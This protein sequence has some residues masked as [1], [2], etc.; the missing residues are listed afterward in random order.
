[1]AEMFLVTSFDLFV[2][3]FKKSVSDSSMGDYAVLNG[4]DMSNLN[5][6]ENQN[7]VLA[8]RVREIVKRYIPVATVEF[9]HWT[10]TPQC[11][12]VRFILGADMDTLKGIVQRLNLKPGDYEITNYEGALAYIDPVT[13]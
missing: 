4:L 6:W 9:I 2:E 7:G 11:F 1:M 3:P 5:D 10:A 12:G 8:I 13:M